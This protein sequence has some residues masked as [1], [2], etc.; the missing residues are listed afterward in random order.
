VLSAP[1]D[2]REERDP[3]ADRNEKWRSATM[4]PG[5]LAREHL[6]DRSRDRTRSATAAAVA[7]HGRHL[8]MPT[9]AATHTSVRLLD[10]DPGLATGLSGEPL[11]LAR[12]VLIAS[13]EPLH[14]GSWRPVPPERPERHLGFLVLE[15]VL[16]RRLPF[17]ERE[18]AELLGPGDLLQPWHELRSSSALETAARW[19]VVEPGALAVLDERVTGMIGRWPE[20]VTTTV[21]RA[22]DRSRAMAVTLGIAQMTGAELRLL[23][24][25][26]H[27]AE[28][29][30]H[31]DGARWIVPIRLS[32]HM[33]AALVRTQRTTVSRALIALAEGGLAERCE[34]G[35]WAL[36]G[37]P[38]E[39]LTSLRR[40][41][42]G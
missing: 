20:L 9:A 7:P 32:H 40:A 31:R 30:G 12:T 29:F 17:G 1:R 15:G 42:V 39:G 37:E 22:L 18:S 11:A 25:L 24:T 21:G 34:N 28:R 3:T 27:L 5:G 19:T 2:A 13:V 16:F 10:A 14:A 4:P 26:W 35:Y 36:S 23:A 41:V 33:L 6:R 38:P 8:T